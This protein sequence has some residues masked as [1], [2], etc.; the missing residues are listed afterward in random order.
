MDTDTYHIRSNAFERKLD[1]FKL[2]RAL[3]HLNQRRGFKSLRKSLEKVSGE[4]AEEACQVKESI[5][6][7]CEDIDRL[8]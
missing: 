5:A 6:A 7:I 4:G 3:Y 1:E 2:S 8:V